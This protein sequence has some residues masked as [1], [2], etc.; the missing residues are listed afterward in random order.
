M[1]MKIKTL[2]HTGL[3]A[4]SIIAR[5]ATPATPHATETPLL[6]AGPHERRS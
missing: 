5:A 3:L 1:N 2:I 6:S 4:S